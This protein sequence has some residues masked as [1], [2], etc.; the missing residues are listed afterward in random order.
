MLDVFFYEAFQEETQAMQRY[1]NPTVKAAFTWQTIQEHA[2]TNLPAPIISIRTQSAIPVAWAS[3]LSGVLTRS[4]GYNHI[5]DYWQKCQSPITYGYLP[6]YCS[7]AVAEQVMLLWMTLLRKLPQQIEKFNN[8]KRDGLTGRECQHKK[9]L[10]VG[11]GHIGYEVAL[12][13]QGLG[14][15]VLGVDIEQ[16]HRDITYVT[17]EQGL[18]QADIVVCAMN[19]TAD[20]KG[21]FNKAVFKRAKPGLIFINIARGELSPAADLLSL[22]QE[23]I[24]GGIALDVYEQEEQLAVSLRK[25]D[26]AD[27]VITTLVQQ[28]NVILTPHN[29]FNTQEA[30]NRKAEQSV[31]QIHHFLEKGNFLWPVPI[32]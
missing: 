32:K 25:G 23:G 16:K 27:Q 22:L 18:T 15:T 1:L 2:S 28:P 13:G 19:L 17:F 31:M 11:V 6:L 21:Y 14:M 8:F 12:I 4:T 9:L 26:K 30:L 10:I 24:L 5:N 3:Q 29:A 20:N 7:R